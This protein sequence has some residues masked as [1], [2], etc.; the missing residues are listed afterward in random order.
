MPVTPRPPKSEFGRKRGVVGV[1][2]RGDKILIIQRSKHV[3]APLKWCLPGGTME[4]GE[5]EEQTLV[6]EMKEELS[7]DV[8]PM[9]LCWRSIT[10]WGTTL[11]WWQ[12]ELDESV[13]PVPDAAEVAQ[14]RWMTQEEIYFAE[15]M[16]PSLPAFLDAVASGE[17]VLE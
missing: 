3:T 15:G 14:Y 2:R 10:P 17:I 16:L 11:A 13:T 8:T 12:A 6:R 1:I 9:R 7:I 5:S 4:K